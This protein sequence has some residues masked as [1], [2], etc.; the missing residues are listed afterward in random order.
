MW[1]NFMILND[2]TWPCAHLT[3]LESHDL[4]NQ[5]PKK[6]VTCSIASFAT[7]RNRRCLE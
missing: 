7:A 6:M 5:L 1:V 4:F 3:N 2:S